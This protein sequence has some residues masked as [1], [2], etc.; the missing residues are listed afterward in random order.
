MQGARAPQPGA[1]NRPS[2]SGHVKPPPPPTVLKR[3]LPRALCGPQG[4]RSASPPFRS[5]R[6]NAPRG[7]AALAAGAHPDPCR[8]RKLSRPAPKVLQG[9]PCGR[10]GRRRPPGRVARARGGDARAGRLG[11]GG[12][13]G[14]PPFRLRAPPAFSRRRKAAGPLGGGRPFAFGAARL[15]S[16]MSTCHAGNVAGGLLILS[17]TSSR[18]YSRSGL[19]LR[20]R[21]GLLFIYRHP[22]CGGPLSRA[23]VRRSSCCL[24][25]ARGACALFI[26]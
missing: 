18:G 2:P 15:A 7:P 19:T 6:R 10:L 25:A 5:P 12:P 9:R 13:E 17:R 3:G 11:G 16:P 23:S 21:R 1:T 8:T 22:V 26:S 24:I 20:A 14:V 4:A